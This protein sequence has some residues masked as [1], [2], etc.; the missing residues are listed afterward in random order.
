MNTHHQ[1]DTKKAIEEFRKGAR[2]SGKSA[3]QIRAEIADLQTL[4]AM[5]EEAEARAAKA[6]D[7]KRATALL[8]AMREAQKEIEALFPGSFSG[9]KWE[10]ITAQA[11]PRDTSFKRAADLSDTEVHEARERGAKAVAAL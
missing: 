11:W 1:Q 7:A 10:A 5:Q 8:K 6:G 2:N 3:E 9:D 4:L